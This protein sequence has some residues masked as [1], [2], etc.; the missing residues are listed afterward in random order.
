[1]ASHSHSLRARGAVR[2]LEVGA[3]YGPNL[4]FVRRPV[5]YWKLEPNTHF[6]ALFLKNLAAN[7]KLND[8]IS[9]GQD[10]KLPVVLQEEVEI[11]E[12]RAGLLIPPQRKW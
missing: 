7:P 4:E 1:M 8:T 10:A 2:V 5:E 12:R 6:D 11:G 9:V 3:A